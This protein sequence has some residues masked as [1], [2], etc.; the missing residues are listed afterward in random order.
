AVA[1]RPRRL[2]WWAWLFIIWPIRAVLAVLRLALRHPA[3]SVVVVVL[4][5]LWRQVGAIHLATAA[6]VV[7][8][9]LAV[10]A[11]VDAASFHRLV[12]W[13]VIGRWRRCST[14]RRGTWRPLMAVLKLTAK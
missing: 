14:Y 2:P 8:S 9:V 7:G 11:V 12:G 13:P 5:W 4:L 1:P 3:A 6:G 10:W